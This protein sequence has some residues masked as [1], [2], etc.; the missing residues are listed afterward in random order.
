MHPAR[1]AATLLFGTVVG[2]MCCVALA[3][4]AGASPDAGDVLLSD[5][6]PGFTLVSEATNTIGA[7]SVTR[8]FE[9]ANAILELTAIPV[10]TPPGV[11]AVFG[12]FSAQGDGFDSVPEPTLDL[13][14]WL[15]SPGSQVGDDGDA[16]LVFASR[17]HVFVSALFTDEA[18]GIDAPAFLRELAQ[19]QVEAAGGP[20]APVDTSRDRSRDDELVALLPV[21]PPAGFGLTTSATATGA[22]ELPDAELQ[23]AVVD[24]LNENSTTATRVWS[25]SAGDLPRQ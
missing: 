21:D 25:D 12:I 4:P 19:R 3:S 10:T 9:H 11:R 1:S 16:S 13:A 20:P 23:S 7:E 8:R 14:G 15:V 18:A 17:D 6:G 5:V 24:F 2:A 22:D